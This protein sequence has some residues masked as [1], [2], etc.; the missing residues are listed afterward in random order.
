[1]IKV[2]GSMTCLS[3]F[4]VVGFAKVWLGKPPI[5]AISLSSTS[6][7]LKTAAT[8]RRWEKLHRKPPIMATM[9]CQTVIVPKLAATGDRFGKNSGGNRQ[10]WP[11][12]LSWIAITPKP[13]KTATG[14]GKSPWKVANHGDHAFFDRNHAKAS[15]NPLGKIQRKSPMMAI[16]LS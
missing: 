5:M 8:R 4:L 16:T 15:N 3:M 2:Y 13:A 14:L 11:S 1:M 7:V 9:L 6:L 10:S 12:C